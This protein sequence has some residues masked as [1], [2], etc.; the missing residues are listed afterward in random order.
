MALASGDVD[1][2]VGG[3]GLVEGGLNRGDSLVV[4]CPADLV[5]ND[6]RGF[7]GSEHVVVGH[8]GVYGDG[9]A[10][11]VCSVVSPVDVGL[12]R[13]L[14]AFDI[15]DVCEGILDLGLRRLLDKGEQLVE[16]VGELRASSALAMDQGGQRVL[17]DSVGLETDADKALSGGVLRVDLR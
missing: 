10:G 2:A 1:G 13:P 9:A 15:Q 7:Q 14:A 6:A 8:R 5:D 4:D 16:L 3:P 17:D 11:H 12:F